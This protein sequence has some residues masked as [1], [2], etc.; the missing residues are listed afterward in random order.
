MVWPLIILLLAGYCT[1]SVKRPLPSVEPVAS[2]TTAKAAV[3]A[4]TLAWP[5]GGEA[6]VSI[7]DT[8]I[9]ETRGEQKSLPMAS[10]AKL[11]TALA[12]LDKKPLKPGEQGPVITLTAND[13]AI[14]NA[15]VAQGGSVMR[16]VPGEQITEYQ[17]LQAIML[18]SANNI[19]DSLA[20]WA[21]GSLDAYSSYANTYAAKLGL[22]DTHIGTDASGMSPTT[23]SSARDLALLGQAAMHDPVLA[24]IVNQSTATGM[25]VVGTVKNVN[26]LLGTDGIVGIKTGNTEEAGGVFVGAARTLV[27]GKQT[28]IVTSVIGSQSLFS[29]M[30]E[31]LNLID[32]A[33]TNFKPVTVTKAGAVVGRYAVPWGGSVAAIATEDLKVDGWGGGSVP[34]AVI[35][36]DVA[37]D[38]SAGTAAGSVKVT[39]CGYTKAASVPVELH[40]SITPPSFWWRLLHPLP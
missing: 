26:F 15:Y 16:I 36:R 6:P 8:P 28:T 22:D 10:T 18:P 37:G 17:M 19:A 23:T 5:P 4:G 13:A 9:L 33:K 34:Y 24:D 32:S 2:V 20:I 3:R 14:Y 21:F 1:W 29:A 25:P 12:V 39:A 40:G 35:L 38:A 30:K 27:N 31:S 7:L 11:I